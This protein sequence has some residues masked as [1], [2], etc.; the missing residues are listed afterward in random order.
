MGR[1]FSDLGPHTPSKHNLSTPPPMIWC[2]SLPRIHLSQKL[3]LPAMLAQNIFSA[4]TPGALTLERGMGM[5][6][7]QYPFFS[8]QSVL[9]SL[10]IYPQ[11]VAHVPPWFSIFRTILHF[12][13]WFGQNLSSQEPNFPNFCSQDPSFFLK[14]NLLTRPY[15]WKPTWHTSTEKKKNKTWLCPLQ[16][17]EQS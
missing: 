12:Q 2:T 14:E 5:C 17:H 7:G 13:P 4:L 3:G 15:F 10:P 16:G 9:P 6:R 8:G 1:G 11:C